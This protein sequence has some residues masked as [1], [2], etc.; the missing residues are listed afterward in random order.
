MKRILPASC[1]LTTMLLLGASVV[2]AQTAGGKRIIGRVTVQGNEQVKAE[3]ILRQ[4][5]SR[6]GAPLSEKLLS[7]DSR[8]IIIMPEILDVKWQVIPAGDKA[9]IVF[10]VTE[11]S[12]IGGLEIQGNKNIETDKLLKDLRFQ[13]D[14]FLDRYLV[15]L[16][17]EAITQKYRDEGYYFAEARVD[18]KL[19]AEEGRVV[20]V[21]VEGPRVR[22]K[23][24]RFEGNEAFAAGKLKSKIST[25][26]YFPVF[27]NGRLDDEKLEQDL[28]TLPAF[29]HDEG[30]LDARVFVRKEFNEDKTRLTLVFVIDEGPPYKVSD[31]AFLG[32]TVP[33]EEITENL[34]LKNGDI[35]TRERRILAKRAIDRSYGERGY[36]FAN[37]GIEPRYTD[38]EGHVD[39]IFRI[40]EGK[41]YQLG[42]VII[43]G[44]YQTQ[45]K[46]VRRDFDHFGFLPGRLYDT[47]ALSKA[48][49]RLKGSGFFDKISVTPIGNA[50]DKRDALV[51]V[52]EGRTGLILFGV[53]VDTNS[54]LLGQF[55]IEQRNFDASNPPKSMTELFTGDA[56][57]GGG[58]RL[59]LNLEPGTRVSRARLKF[60]EPYLFDQNNYM[61]LSLFLF[62]RGRESHLEERAGGMVALGHRFE[63]DWSADVGVRA[64]M[65]EISDLE[66]DSIGVTAPADVQD[67]EGRNFL[68]SLKFG[69]TCDKTDSFF[70]PSEG[71]KV[72]GSWEQA[73]ALG[74]DFTYASVTTTLTGFR[75]IYM[76]LAER[77]TVWT[78]QIRA[79]H[80][81]GAAPVFERF[82]AGGLG[83]LRGFDY[84]GVSPRQ[85]P[86][87]DPIGSEWLFL[88]ASEITHPIHEEVLF[89][90]LFCDSGV[91]SEGRYRV[92]VGFGVELLVPQLFQMI[93]MNFDFGF[94]ILSDDEDDEQVFSFSLGMSF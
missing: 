17:A 34:K 29:Y 30:H 16:G 33:I 81:M 41:P 48:E 88:A 52:T 64:E 50:P 19:L 11:A 87:R 69:V 7:E 65:V 42:R 75:T 93:P 3:H 40:E 66:V 54:G 51:E 21:V 36:I 23:K 55:S 27:V 92:T 32:N 85:G 84:R 10:T 5:Y 58:Q 76:D 60:H 25:K 24:I 44:N 53:G 35:L 43:Q 78:N 13:A 22:I 77:K 15:R 68:T 57:V 39:V 28:I 63:N 47:A 67:V 20:Y 1:L 86:Y 9:D 71:Y 59:S 12:R 6:S 83:S 14:D 8:R 56:F 49:K 79:G 72:R 31:I 18:E 46:V 90:K 89:A 38:T 26:A 62:R 4:V 37:V 82:Y 91:V 94:P 61:D 73:G 2:S 74:G 45:D 80:I 70:R